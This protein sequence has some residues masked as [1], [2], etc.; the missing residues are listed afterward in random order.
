MQLRV[1]NQLESIPPLSQQCNR[2]VCHFM[3]QRPKS[4]FQYL[5]FNI[6]LSTSKMVMA[7]YITLI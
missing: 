6:Q 5:A 4:G 3:F 2:A 7:I 1:K